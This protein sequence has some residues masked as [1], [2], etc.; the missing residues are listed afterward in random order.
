MAVLL[1]NGDKSKIEKEIIIT[2]EVIPKLISATSSVEDP[3]SSK[4]RPFKEISNESILSLP[5][6]RFDRVGYKEW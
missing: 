6:I 2:N 3:M 1:I 4:K 5:A